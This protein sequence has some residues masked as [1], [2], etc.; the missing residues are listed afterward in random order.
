MEIKKGKPG[1]KDFYDA[2]LKRKVCE[3]LLSGQSYAKEVAKKYGIKGA[4]TVVTWLK[5]Y[6]KE[7]DGFVVPLVLMEPQKTDD[8]LKDIKPDHNLEEALMLAKLKIAGLEAMIDI[9]EK[10]FNI[11]IRKKSGTKQS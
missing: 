8:Q 6:Q 2:A 4:G 5:K 9:A 10:T 3:E 7:Q 1:R 11:D